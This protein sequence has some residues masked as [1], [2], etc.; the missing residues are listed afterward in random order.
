MTFSSKK[1]LNV[2][3]G[4][5]KEPSHRDG[6]FEYPKYMFLMRNKTKLL[7]HEHCE[8]CIIVQAMEGVLYHLSRKKVIIFLSTDLL[9]SRVQVVFASKIAFIS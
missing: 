3:F 8:D 4:C 6:S 9:A 2:C 7:A 5:S 1:R